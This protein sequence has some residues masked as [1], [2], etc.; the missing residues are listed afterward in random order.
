MQQDPAPTIKFGWFM[1]AEGIPEQEK[2]PLV[3]DEEMQVLPVVAEHFDSI[4]VQDHFYAFRKPSDAWLECWTTIT[5]LAARFPRLH[6]G[7]IVLGVGYRNPALLAKMAATLQVLSEGRFIMGIGAGWRSSEYAAYSFPFPPTLTRVQQLGEAVEI[8]RLMWTQEAPSFQ[9]QHFRLENAYCEPRP[10]FPPPIMI[11]GGGEKL[12][13][14]LVGRMAD[15]WD[16]Y[17]GG[18][19]GE[20]DL[21]SYRR[22]RDI[23]RKHAAEAG[24]EPESVAQSFTIENG[25][26]PG[27]REDSDTWLT[28]L[29]P[30]VD[31]GVRQFILGFGHVTEADKVR[32]FA[33]EVIAPLRADANR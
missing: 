11:G 14:P 31:L 13:L 7:P 15:I 18:A 23:V 17:H 24:R 9:G 10:A 22:K 16:R 19:P 5:W 6:V 4:W 21:E 26:L 27:S 30:L 25:Q 32:R 33:E 3:M 12:V 1:S 2:V 28:H 8:L 29:R 20:V